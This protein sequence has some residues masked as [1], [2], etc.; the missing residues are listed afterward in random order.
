VI[1]SL[2]KVETVVVTPLN[3]VETKLSIPVQTP[4]M[5]ESA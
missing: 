5:V 4:L 3:V 1:T 2:T